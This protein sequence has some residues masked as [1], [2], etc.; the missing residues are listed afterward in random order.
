V[1]RYVH[2][3]EEVLIRTLAE[4]GVA[5]ARS[6]RRE[7]VTSVWVG[8]AK[9]AAIGIHVARWVTTHG[10]AL[11]VTDE[12]LAAFAGIV[13]CGITDGGVTSIARET[14]TAPALDALALAR[15][16]LPHFA[17]VFGRD[18]VFRAPEG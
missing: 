18:V 4:L 3:L 10:F 6:E 2:D 9:I 12:P 8:N 5:S 17:S 13:P 16:M 11:N 15:R 1:K 14:G 7:R